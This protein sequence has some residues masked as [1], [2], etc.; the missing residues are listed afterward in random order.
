[1]AT[2][3]VGFRKDGKYVLWFAG[4]L[5]LTT[6]QLL[7]K[8]E[9]D[10]VAVEQ[11]GKVQEWDNQFVQSSLAKKL[12]LIVTM[13][14]ELFRVDF[15]TFPGMKPGPTISKLRHIEDCR[16]WLDQQLAYL[17]AAEELGITEENAQLF[18]GGWESYLAGQSHPEDGPNMQGW[19]AADK[20]LPRVEVLSGTSASQ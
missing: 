2:P 5:F 8:D 3:L 9:R 7:I 16:P 19:L 4:G 10:I 14:G 13:Q 12:T 18:R 1:M 11:T 17:E 20:H 15:S 6:R